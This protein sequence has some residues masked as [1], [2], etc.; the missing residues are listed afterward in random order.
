ML[1]KVYNHITNLG[2]QPEE[3]EYL[4]GKLRL[5]NLFI[6]IC[7]L[8]S[9]SY[10]ILFLFLQRELQSMIFIGLLILF[11]FLFFLNK[12]QWFDLSRHLFILS[13]STFTLLLS[14]FF[15]YDSG[16]EYYYIAFP[17]IPFSIFNYSRTK[18]IIISL[19]FFISGFILIQ[20]FHKIDY[21]AFY[22][23][24]PWTQNFLEHFNMYLAFTFGTLLT[25]NFA[26]TNF[27]TSKDLNEKNKT[28]LIQKTKLNALLKDKNSLLA[29][30]HHR[31]KNNLAVISGL[32]C[33]QM[34]FTENEIVN[35]V[36]LKSKARIKSMSM[37]HEYLYS[38]EILSEIPLNDFIARF[39]NE[40][41]NFFFSKEKKITYEY[42]ISDISLD[43][44]HAVP[45]TLILN[46]VLTNSFK[47]AFV[48]RNGG[49]I[50]IKCH[51]K[52][53]FI[54]L[55]ILDD[56]IGFQNDKNYSGLGLTLIQALSNQLNGKGNYVSMKEGSHFRLEFQL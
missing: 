34:D 27:K 6:S 16:F 12:K 26:Y 4:N 5:F 19:L 18:E 49:K 32:F 24:D 47:H 15:G 31:V 48:D 23:I 35:E 52:D 38:E 10:V 51:Q 28:L 55:E 44:S 3:K 7:A 46:E 36:L 8:F 30:T 17:L 21:P 53:S 41:N 42:H 20:Y 13:I 14:L 11:I 33:L 37:I 29:E 45:F 43:L 2:I 40:F 9:I 54:F 25:T 1:L 56:G 22:A 39:V 50:I